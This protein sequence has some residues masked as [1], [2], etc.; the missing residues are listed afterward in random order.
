MLTGS[1]VWAPPTSHHTVYL[2]LAA[3]GAQISRHEAVLSD[4]TDLIALCWRVPCENDYMGNLSHPGL[5]FVPDLGA[6]AHAL[7]LLTL[8][9]ASLDL[10]QRAQSAAARCSNA[11]AAVRARLHV[12][13][14]TRR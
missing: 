1:G 7:T 2:V 12:L 10:E 3:D 13:H 4:A 14:A 9:R 11:R 5:E 6:H 8:R